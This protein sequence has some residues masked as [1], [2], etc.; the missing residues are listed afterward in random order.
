MRSYPPKID[1]LIFG[2]NASPIGIGQTRP[3]ISWRYVQDE[4][5]SQ[6]WI[7][8]SFEVKIGRQH[9]ENICS[10]QSD[11]NFQIEWPAKEEALTSREKARIAVRAC[12]VD[13]QWTD[14]YEKSLEVALVEAKDWKAEVITTDIKQPS[15]LPKRPFYTRTSF[16]LDSAKLD[17]IKKGGARI[18]ATALGVYQLEIN[19]KRAGDHVLAPGWQSYNH[20]LHY[21]IY[22]I[23]AA[24]FREGE[25]VLG[26]I[27]GEGW[28]AGRLTWNE[29]TRNFWGDE[30]GVKVQLEFGETI[31]A[32]DAT[33]KWSFGP[34]LTSELYDGE[35]FDVAQV[36]KSWSSSM[37][38]SS[39]WDPVR[40][41]QLP[42]SSELIAPEAPPIRRT[43]EINA[44]TL[45]TT[46]KGKKIIDFGQNIARWVRLQ[47]I[48]PKG[49]G[50]GVIKLRFAEVLDRGE[51]GMRPLR[52]A[53]CTDTIYCA[54]EPFSN[55]EP[56]FT[57]H[58]FRY[59]EVNG[60]GED[61]QLEQ[62][63]AVVVHS[64]MERL[65]DFEC[66]HEMINKLHKN[67]VWGLRG[68]FVGLPTDCPQ[69][70]ER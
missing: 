66:S 24:L 3:T 70:D 45:I 62:F 55:W 17:G 12:G 8:R 20:R 10:V 44:S 67:V 49:S 6:D 33:W 39:R 68:N 25:N 50:T 36:D 30:I 31:I 41:L 54:N 69:R 23:P 27:V 60:L 19:G 26:A 63:V 38:T 15:R 34:L 59:M 1:C 57:T 52:T 46:P 47:S 64:D 21:Q 32:S 61:V 65:G 14:W 7:Q 16:H 22:I 37:S 18:Y 43:S 48:P 42:S 29:D 13:G 35:V 40:I 5:T 4:T 28:Y 2:R 51:I 58:G 56:L 9:G 53:K 11:S